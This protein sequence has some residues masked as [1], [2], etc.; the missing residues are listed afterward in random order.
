VNSANW[1]HFEDL[2]IWQEGRQLASTIYSLLNTNR[3]WGFRQQI[4]RACVSITNNIA[5][6]FERSG[7]REFRHFLGIAKGSCGEVR[8]MLYIAL[9]LSYISADTFDH[10]RART[11][12][13]S[14]KISAL[15]R[16]IDTEL[17]RDC[18]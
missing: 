2:E 11:N 10:L 18:V 8:S 3:D 9:D 12:R 15:M 6:G 14:R 7:R 16:Y 17:A 13:L 1:S 4:Q 5:E